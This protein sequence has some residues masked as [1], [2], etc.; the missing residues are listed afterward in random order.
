[1]SR[2]REA[3]KEKRMKELKKREMCPYPAE[4]VKPPE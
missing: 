2:G 4:A 1:V 3:E